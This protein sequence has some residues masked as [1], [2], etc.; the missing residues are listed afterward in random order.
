MAAVEVNDIEL[1]SMIVGNSMVVLACF[2]APLSAPWM[3]F[4]TVLDEIDLALGDTIMVLK[5]NSLEN[6][7]F[8][9]HLEIYESPTTVAFRDGE[10]VGRWNGNRPLLA[11]LRDL[12]E[13][14]KGKEGA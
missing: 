11:M 14:I 12:D 3:R 5:M 4:R 13:I 2:W 7:T 6:P 10:E 1:E 8:C 9:K